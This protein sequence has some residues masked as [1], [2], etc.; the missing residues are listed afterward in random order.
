MDAYNEEL[1]R[2]AYQ[3]KA[4]SRLPAAEVLDL[5]IAFFAARGYR[6]GRTGRP[7]QVFVMGKAEGRLPRVTGEVSARADVG[8]PGTTLVTM[9]AVGEQL[10]PTMAEFHRS[11]R[12]RRSPAPATVDGKEPA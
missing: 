10:G 9:D 5:A 11:L 3:K 7:N 2:T 12:S 4:V 6:A 1:K 8:K